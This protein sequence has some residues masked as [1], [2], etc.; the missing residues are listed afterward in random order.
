MTNYQEER[1]K[2]TNTQLKKLKSAGK[3]N[4]GAILRITEKNFQA[5]ELPH[6]LFLTKR[7]KVTIKNAFTDNMSTDIKLQ[8]VDFLVKQQVIWAKKLDL[9]VPLAKIFCQS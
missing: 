6:E 9:G 4:D 3:N 5:E 1:V 2:L 8:Q 7:Q